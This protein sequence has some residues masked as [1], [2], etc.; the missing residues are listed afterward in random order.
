MSHLIAYPGL[1]GSF[2]YGAARHQFPDDEVR[3]YETFEE[4]ARAVADGECTYGLLPIENSS[5][6]AV[7][8]TYA[9]LEKMQ[10]HIVGE[11]LEPVR[12]QLVG[13]PK[14][15]LSRIRSITSHPQA[16]AQCD[17]FLSTLKGVQLIPGVNTAI[18]ARQLLEDADE[19]RAAIA[20][21]EAAEFFGL[22]ILKE[23]IHTSKVNTTRFFILSKDPQPLYSP[24]KATVVFRVN[25]VVGALVQVLISFAISGLN[26]TRIE[27]RP[28]KDEP[29]LYFFSA[30]FEGEMDMNHLD[31]AMES[32][33]PFTSDLRLLGTYRK[34]QT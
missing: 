12:H 2:S 13:L 19:T 5:A 25:N 23:D 1:A 22:K 6:G 26:M 10:L 29:F 33:R 8:T 18:C 34:A 14:A 31:R 21:R 3:G 9:I 30:D 11:A 32:A 20:S 15:E 16:I 24:N 7:L 27:S 28:V 17:E 4:A